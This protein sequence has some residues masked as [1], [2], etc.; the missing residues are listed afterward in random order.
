MDD[1]IRHTPRR[2][3]PDLIKANNQ[4]EGGAEHTPSADLHRIFRNHRTTLSVPPQ[5]HGV[6]TTHPT[7]QGAPV[8]PRSRSL[9]LAAVVLTGAVALGACGIDTNDS[10]MGGMGPGTA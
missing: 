6:S 10:S 8:R 1:L 5:T 7:P 9:G 4:P 3:T 2:G